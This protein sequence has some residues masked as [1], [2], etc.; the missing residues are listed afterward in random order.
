MTAREKRRLTAELFLRAAV[1]LDRRPAHPKNGACFA[2][3]E[4]RRFIRNRNKRFEVQLDAGDLM[5]S[6]FEGDAI[7]GGPDDIYWGVNFGAHRDWRARRKFFNSVEY[8]VDVEAAKRGRILM[9]LFL[10]AMV[11]AGDA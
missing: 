8:M 7:R 3:K 5:D 4:A 2:L 10:A 11:K 9:L 1:W 6:L